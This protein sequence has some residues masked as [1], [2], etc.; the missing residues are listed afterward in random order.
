MGIKFKCSKCQ[1][2]LTL[3]SGNKGDMVQCHH[4][5]EVVSIPENAV[6][7]SS[8]SPSQD[9]NNISSG[10]IIFKNPKTGETQTTGTG[11][12]WI[13]CLFSGAWGIP[14]FLKRAY[15][16][17]FFFLFLHLSYLIVYPLSMLTEDMTPAVVLMLAELG[18]AV[19]MGLRG[20]RQLTINYL[21]NG[22]IIQNPESS[23]VIN[24][25]K[26][27]QLDVNILEK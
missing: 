24:T 27:W 4:C 23:D 22:W 12:S 1:K 14:L 5:S 6:V 11:W 7:F 9:S 16:W 25:I 15:N 20:N 3:R 21:E 10:K 19:Y 8:S 13:L 26:K 18:F 2:D 17:A